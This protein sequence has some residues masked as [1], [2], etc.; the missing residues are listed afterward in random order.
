LPRKHRII[1]ALALSAV[2]LIIMTGCMSEKT[3]IAPAN[4]SDKTIHIGYI[5]A[6]QL[7]SP[8]VLVMREK[9]LLEAAGFNVEWHE[10]IAGAHA[11]QDMASG[12]VDFAICGSAPVI[13]NHSQGLDLSILAGSNQ[14]GSGLVVLDSIESVMDLDGKTIASPGLGSIQDAMLTRL[15][16][17]YRISIHRT[18]MDVFDMPG[19]LKKKEIDGFIAWEPHP[20]NAVYQK[21]GYELLT[22]KDMMPKHQCCVLITKS[23][24]LRNDQETV[25]KVLE[26]YLDSY[27]WFMENQEESTL[28]IAKATGINEAVVREAMTTVY[29]CYPPYCNVSSMK[30]MTQGLIDAGRIT[31]M[32]EAK[33]D[34]F[35]MDIYQPGLMEAI[36]NTRRPYD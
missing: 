5:K 23:A 15:A 26:V 7:H 30:S 28:M 25:V 27:K 18:T 32:D 9:K 13:I 6:D 16:M 4:G 14:E 21:Y 20:A 24:T 10:Y 33:I 29:Y 1:L 8:A 11:I 12:T 2:I 34:D 3:D 19:F 36:T 35:I 31:A 22:S 17:D